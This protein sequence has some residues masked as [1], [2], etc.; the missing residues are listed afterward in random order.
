MDGG[1]HIN[2]TWGGSATAGPP[3]RAWEALRALHHALA[4]AWAAGA[5]WRDLAALATASSGRPWSRV[6]VERL[7]A[8]PA[9]RELASRYGP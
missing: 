1:G 9:F 3:Q 5:S 8:S 7:T 6:E 4:Q 2:A